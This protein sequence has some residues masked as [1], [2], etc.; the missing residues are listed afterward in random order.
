MNR[1]RICRGSVESFDSPA[2]MKCSTCPIVMLRMDCTSCC[3]SVLVSVFGRDGLLGIVSVASLF[4]SFAV[5]V[6]PE[7]FPRYR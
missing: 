4:I 6:C 5:S 3:G 7:L 1:I 2:S